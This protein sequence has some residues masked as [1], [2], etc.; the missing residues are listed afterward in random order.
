MSNTDAPTRREKASSASTDR[1]SLYG[2]AGGR[3]YL[4]RSES[5]RVLGALDDLRADR[6]LFAQTLAWTGARISEVL[7]LTPG[8]FQVEDCIAAIVT[9]KRRK[10]CVREV[11]IPPA[12]MRAL[13]AHFGISQAQR[14]GTDHGPLWPWCRVTGWRIV[15]TA[16]NRSGI[17]GRQAC[18]RGLRHGFGVAVLQAGVPL[19][20]A[21]KWLGHARLSTTAIYAAACGPEE[22]EFAARYWRA[23][24]DVDPRVSVSARDFTGD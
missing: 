17:L 20:L 18:P 12:L 3:K 13:D 24:G 4:N 8:S 2:E 23:M 7:A 5:L 16:M 10:F 19:T 11:P 1:A 9:L 15:K 6:A 22:R 21:Q 14:C